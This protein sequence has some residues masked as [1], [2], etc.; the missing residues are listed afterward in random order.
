LFFRI[1]QATFFNWIADII[2]L[3]PTEIMTTWYKSYEKP[4]NENNENKKRGASY[5]THIYIYKRKLYR[6]IS[7]LKKSKKGMYNLQTLLNNYFYH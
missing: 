5:N 3:I 2:R 4:N 6:K 7:L 1:N